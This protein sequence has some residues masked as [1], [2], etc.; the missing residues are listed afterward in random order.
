MNVS[1]SLVGREAGE[2]RILLSQPINGTMGKA[3]ESGNGFGWAEPASATR[4]LG[5]PGFLYKPV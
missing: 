2:A 5:E 1:R 3:K 4:R